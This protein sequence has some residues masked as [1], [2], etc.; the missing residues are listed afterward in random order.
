LVKSG[1]NE[2]EDEVTTPLRQHRL[3]SSSDE[4]DDTSRFNAAYMSSLN[5]TSA[6]EGNIENVIAISIYDNCM[7]LV[8]LTSNDDEVGSNSAMKDEPADPCGKPPIDG[9]NNFFLVILV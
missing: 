5:D 4:P 6:W 8:N 9:D 2:E 7:P 1:V 3:V